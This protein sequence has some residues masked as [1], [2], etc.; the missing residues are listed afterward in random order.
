MK[1]KLW[2]GSYTTGTEAR[3]IVGAELEGDSL[4][5]TGESI[6][7]HDPSWLLPVENR[8]YWVD[9]ALGQPA[10]HVVMAR[11]SESG[12]DTVCEVSTE[13]GNPC[14]LSVSPD[15]RWMAAAN[16]AS[17]SVAVYALSADGLPEL[18]AVLPGRA[19]GPNPDRQRG[20]H[21]HFTAFEDGELLI[22]DLGGDLL[23]RA[24]LEDGRWHEAEPKL[25]F[26]AGSGPRHM[27]RR[28]RY[29]YIVCELGNDLETFDL[30]TG[31]LLARA[32]VAPGANGSAAALRMDAAGRLIASHR[33]GDCVAAFSLE[34][35]A[36]P[37]RVSVSPCGG[38]CPRDVLP[39]GDR[40]LCACQQENAVTL[41]RPN[42]IGGF[43]PVTRLAVPAPVALTPR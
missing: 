22:C 31:E 7:A 43:A 6:A 14:H 41:L 15:G 12:W 20:P 39:V 13:G 2:I 25:R 17:G 28:G 11:P 23:R 3:G 27:V 5:L 30:V 40:L 10:G 35:P 32:D 26:P 37:R 16:Y 8:L 42:A 4:R 29:G 38:A 18:A 19:S 36:L 9:E 1:Q 21:A 24:V 33:G 34:N